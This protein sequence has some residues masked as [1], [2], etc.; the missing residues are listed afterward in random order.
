MLLL[1]VEFE[2][3]LSATGVCLN[4]SGATTF[5]TLTVP[6]KIIK[7]TIATNPALANFLAHRTLLSNA[8]KEEIAKRPTIGTAEDTKTDLFGNSK[9]EKDEIVKSI[10]MPEITV[11]STIMMSLAV[12]DVEELDEASEEEDDDEGPD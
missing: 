12:M 9:G 6:M 10:K 2:T 7:I 11:A 3:I 4:I 5:P 1:P 8:N